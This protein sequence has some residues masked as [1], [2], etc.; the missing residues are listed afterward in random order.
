MIMTLE[1]RQRL[2]HNMEKNSMSSEEKSLRTEHALNGGDW[3]DS[4]GTIDPDDY[5]DHPYWT[6]GEYKKHYEK[7]YQPDNDDY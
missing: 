2:I 1:K 3:F 7:N 4:I 6:S 5:P